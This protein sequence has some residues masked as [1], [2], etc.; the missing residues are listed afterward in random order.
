MERHS[1]SMSN[2]AFSRRGLLG[3]GAVAGAAAATFRGTDRTTRSAAMARDKTRGRSLGTPTAEEGRLLARPQ[4]RVEAAPTGLHPLGLEDRRDG[5][6]YVPP[7]YR[8]DQPAPLAVMLHGAGGDA[9]HGLDLL[10]PL[11]DAAGLILLAPA[12]R[13]RTWDVILGRYGPDIDFIDRALGQTFARYAVDP[14]RLA[15]GGFSDGASYALSIGI[16]NG[17]L[18]S[19]I[20]AFSPGFMAPADQRG[21][22]RVYISHGTRD[23]VLPIDVCSRRIVPQLER[24]RYEVRYTEFD[25]PHTVPPE[26]TREALDWFLADRDRAT[27]A[28]SPAA[29]R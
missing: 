26:I 12:S 7:S 19:H 28:A 23:E 27:P 9:P 25:G 4:E 29:R 15:V 14:D 3:L 10:R 2:V 5:L 16:T 11:A 13:G 24:A 6:L 22:P 1:F 17:D 20:V 21:E 18:F 8:A